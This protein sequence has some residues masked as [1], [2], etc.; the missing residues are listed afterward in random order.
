MLHRCDGRAQGSARSDVSHLVPRCRG[1]RWAMIRHNRRRVIV[2]AGKH[3]FT[4]VELLVVLGIT[5]I[6]FALLLPTLRNV[7]ASSRAIKCASN[8][9]SIGTMT[10]QYL[11]TW[12]A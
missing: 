1:R 2:S 4:L 3:A 10:F 5:A 7:R 11:A 12:R 9:R 6:L 8:M